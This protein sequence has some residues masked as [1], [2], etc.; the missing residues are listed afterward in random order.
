MATGTGKTY[1]AIGCIDA[2]ATSKSPTLVAIVPF[3]HLVQ[4]WKSEIDK[5]GLSIDERLSQ[6]E[7]TKTGSG[8]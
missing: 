8:S 4:Q 2:V 7:P 6:M 3:N 5:F 1:T